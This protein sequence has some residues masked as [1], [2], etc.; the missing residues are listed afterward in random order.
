MPAKTRTGPPARSG[1]ATTDTPAIATV[2]RGDLCP[3]R[4]VMTTVLTVATPSWTLLA[5]ARAMRQHRVSGLP[6]VDAEARVVG[7]ISEKDLLQDLDR[8]VGIGH[9]RGFLDLL[10]ELEGSPTASRLENC[11]RRLEG[12]HVS[13]AMSTP[14][15][16]IGPETTVAEASRILRHRGFK[17]LPVVERG[18]LIGL[19]T[20]ANLWDAYPADLDG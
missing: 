19:I 13:E 15:V 14:A 16:T 20:Q 3:V 7:V 9:I 6:V 1:R 4:A 17:R 12:G 5:A 10:L 11:L 2:P 8:S 18:R